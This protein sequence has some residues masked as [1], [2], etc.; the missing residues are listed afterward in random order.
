[1]N[2][3]FCSGGGLQQETR[4]AFCLHRKQQI[5]T[6]D[7]RS[8]LCNRIPSAHNCRKRSGL[9]A[10]NKAKRQF[11]SLSSHQYDAQFG[12]RDPGGGF[13]YSPFCVGLVTLVGSRRIRHLASLVVFVDG[14]GR[15]GKAVRQ[16][17]RSAERKQKS[18]F[19]ESKARK[20]MNSGFFRND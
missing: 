6:G 9:Y 2:F 10:Q 7:S 11:L 19:G 20:T 16:H 18:L 1:M 12:G 17:A 14:C 15:M 3:A 8:L 13:A 5:K 4:E